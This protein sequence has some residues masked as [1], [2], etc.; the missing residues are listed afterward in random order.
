MKV[1]IFVRENQYG[2]QREINAFIKD[3]QVI[4]I[5]F[6]TVKKDL[7]YCYTACVLYQD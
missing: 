6:S 1:E 2:L 5:S 4:N 3:K 7:G